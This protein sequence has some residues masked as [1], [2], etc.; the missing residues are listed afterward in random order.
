[1][2]KT[3]QATIVNENDV[4]IIVDFEATPTDNEIETPDDMPNI[5]ENTFNYDIL[6]VSL[7]LANSTIDITNKCKDTD[8][9][10][11]LHEQ[12]NIDIFDL[13]EPRR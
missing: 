6:K 11:F 5:K 4:Q 7:V 9:K 8:I 12:I 1:M 2:T 3:L 13:Y 10:G